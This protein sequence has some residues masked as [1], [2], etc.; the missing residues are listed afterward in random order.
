MR[1]LQLALLAGG[2]AATA[3]G[4]RETSF[5][6]HLD[7]PVQHH[8]IAVDAAGYAIVDKATHGRISKRWL[9]APRDANLWP[10]KTVRFCYETQGCRDRLHV[11]FKVAMKLWRTVGLGADQYKMIEVADPGISC[12]SHNERATILVIECAPAS[13]VSMWAHVGMPVVN[14]AMPGDYVGPVAH[15]SD[16]DIL[17]APGAMKIAHE[18]GHVWGLKHESQYV[19]FWCQPYNI[20][21]PGN[22][23]E[24]EAATAFGKTF[25]STC[26]N[27]IG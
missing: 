11:R 1:L 21:P 20:W 3:L 14:A 13:S 6:R 15:L 16:R 25:E 26:K 7:S 22:Q 2:F 19:G 17:P 4:G 27:I 8:P 9:G 23:A 10:Q 5:Q 24:S 12:T 18:I